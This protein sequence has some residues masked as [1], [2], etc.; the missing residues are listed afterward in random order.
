MK[1]QYI[2]YKPHEVVHDGKIYKFVNNE[3]KEVP[4]FMARFL[5]SHYPENMDSAR[6]R[7]M[8]FKKVK[9]KI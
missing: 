6:I 3:I 2:G 8:I 5:M 1:I 9:E 4:D 7:G